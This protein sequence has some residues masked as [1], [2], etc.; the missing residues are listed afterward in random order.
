MKGHLFVTCLDQF[1]WNIQKIILDLAN[2][3]FK[4]LSTKLS[5]GVLI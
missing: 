4:N 2:E 3:I 1:F 5:I